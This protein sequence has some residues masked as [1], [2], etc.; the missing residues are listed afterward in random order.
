MGS[1]FSLVAATLRGV[2][3]WSGC[4]IVKSGVLLFSDEFGDFLFLLLYIP[5]VN[6]NETHGFSTA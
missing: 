3:S 2:D 4:F 5:L 6:F 1:N